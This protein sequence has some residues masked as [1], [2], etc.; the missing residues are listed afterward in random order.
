MKQAKLVAEMKCVA[1]GGKLDWYPSARNRHYLLCVSDTCQ[2]QR[3]YSLQ[4]HGTE[5]HV[6]SG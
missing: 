5:K 4:E 3:D 2:D 6:L 1:C